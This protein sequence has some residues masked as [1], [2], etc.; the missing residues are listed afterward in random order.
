[1][2]TLPDLNTRYVRQI[3]YWNALDHGASTI[4]PNQVLT[5]ENIENWEAYDNGI[6]GSIN[7][8]PALR[9]R[10]KTDGWMV[11]YYDVTYG[12]TLPEEFLTSF[13]A[14]SL[15]DLTQTVLSEEIN[16]LRQELSNSGE[17]AFNHTDVGLFNYKYPDMN[18]YRVMH[19]DADQYYGSAT[20]GEYAFNPAS[21][22]PYHYVIDAYANGSTV[23]F[24]GHEIA[25]SGGS[26]STRNRVRAADAGW[27]DTPGYYYRTRTDVPLAGSASHTTL[28]V[29]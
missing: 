3:G 8:H 1:M 6:E 28:V 5:Y 15:P 27:I 7:R 2:V 26:G 12:D 18:H 4:F 21:P 9:Y 13:D 25:D 16:S 10:V 19:S 29:E 22:G 24:D 23:T 14:N 17:M 11:V 20:D